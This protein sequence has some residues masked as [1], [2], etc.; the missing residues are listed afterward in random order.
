MGYLTVLQ[1]FSSLEDAVSERLRRMRRLT[2]SVSRRTGV[3]STIAGV[4]D[5]GLPGSLRALRKAPAPGG[6]MQKIGI[7]LVWVPEPTFASCAVGGA[8]IAA[9]KYMEKRYNGATLHTIGSE[10]SDVISSMRQFRE[11]M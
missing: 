7:G 10:T 11:I 1:A 8:M 3:Y 4:G 9:G 5:A 2:E 6:K